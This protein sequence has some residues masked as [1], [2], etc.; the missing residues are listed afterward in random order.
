MFQLHILLALEHLWVNYTS[1]LS[2]E[3][4]QGIQRLIYI[5][6]TDGIFCSVISDMVCIELA[7]DREYCFFIFDSPMKL[8][9]LDIILIQCMTI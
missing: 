4:V 2:C 1:Q 6:S 8:V 9:S 5:L 7:C 3:V